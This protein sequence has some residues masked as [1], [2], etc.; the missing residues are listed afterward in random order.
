MSERP[1]N[2]L[3]F[4]RDPDALITLQHVLENAGLDT[5]ITWDEAETRNLVANTNFL[6][7]LAP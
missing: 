5:T 1:F 7:H 2:I 4:D 6:S 3:I